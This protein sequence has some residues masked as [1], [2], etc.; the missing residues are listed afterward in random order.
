MRILWI[1]IIGCLVENFS[2]GFTDLSA[3]QVNRDHAIAAA[4]GSASTKHND[5][6][7]RAAN[8]EAWRMV[9]KDGLW[10]YWTPQNNW[11]I[12]SGAKWLAYPRRFEAYPYYGP[13]EDGGRTGIEGSLQ[14][15]LAAPRGLRAYNEVPTG[16]SPF[17][18]AF[19][20]WRGPSGFG[21]RTTTNPNMPSMGS[22]YP[23]PS[24]TGGPGGD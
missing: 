5:P 21:S 17:F 15:P 24:Q 18:R 3:Q 1:A 16:S 22:G 10:W 9:Y 11:L 20:D 19:G 4:T 14:Y 7:R 13:V 12:W 2:A 8:G 23:L 6:K